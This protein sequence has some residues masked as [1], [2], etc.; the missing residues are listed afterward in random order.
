MKRD[1]EGIQKLL[2]EKSGTGSI[3]GDN[4]EKG[5]FGRSYRTICRPYYWARDRYY[6]RGNPLWK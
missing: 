3:I 1:I 2:D 4:K 5:G 6:D